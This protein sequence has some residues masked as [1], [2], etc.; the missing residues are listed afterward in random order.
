MIK[1][2]LVDDEKLIREGLKILLS[3]DEEIEIVG[4][5]GSGLEAY[6]LFKDTEVDVILM[7]IRMPESNGIE[8][9]KMIKGQGEKPVKILILT[10][11]KDTEYINEAIGLGASGYLLKDSEVESLVGGIKSVYS[12]NIVLDKDITDII[13]AGQPINKKSDFRREDYDIT[14]REYEILVLVAKGLSNQEIAD[15]LFLSLGTIKN[16]IS[17]LLQ[18]LDLRDRTQMVIFAYENHIIGA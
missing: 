18:K 9:I 16:A 1:V 7:D 4:E 12:G 17:L 15:S 14:K 10:T 8:G 6:K 13:I 5:A 3:T 2:I 11:F